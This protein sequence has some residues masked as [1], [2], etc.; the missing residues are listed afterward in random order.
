MKP[1]KT[2]PST[3]RTKKSPITAIIVE[4]KTKP[5]VAEPAVLSSAQPPEQKE[6]K[7]QRKK[8]VKT[9]A[10]ELGETKP[11]VL[12]QL[13]VIVKQLGCDEAQ[14]LLEEARTVEAN[15]GMLINDGTRRRTFGG[16]YFALT[17]RAHPDLDC[18]RPRRKKPAGKVANEA[19][20]Q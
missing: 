17:R 1:Q 14:R 18:F 12:S 10:S 4:H 13:H 16:V 19:K 2:K 5:V 9:L 7:E 20:Q 8:V 11:G 15:G 6:D 3:K